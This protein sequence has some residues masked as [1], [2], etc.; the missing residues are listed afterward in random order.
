MTI[1]TL[2]RGALINNGGVSAL[3]ST[4]VYPV[5][6]PQTPTYPAM[7]FQ[8]ISNTGQSGTSD[9]KQSRWQLDCWASSYTAGQALAAAV[10]A[11]IE[12]FHDLDQTPG[13][14]IGRVVNELDDYDDVVKVYRVIVDVML[15]T[16]GD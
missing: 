5:F 15:H 6:L 14:L 2:L 13:I 16:T 3:V 7:S 10:K 11:A 12:E 8:R 9:L 1:S 4:R